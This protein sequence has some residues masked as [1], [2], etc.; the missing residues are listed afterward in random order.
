MAA[1]QEALDALIDA[2]HNGSHAVVRASAA[3]GLGI[4]GEKRHV[5][6]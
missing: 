6:F 1:N 3:E 2:L 5:R 4:M